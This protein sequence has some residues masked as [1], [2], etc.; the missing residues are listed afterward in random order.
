MFKACNILRHLIKLVLLLPYQLLLCAHITDW[1]HIPLRALSFLALIFLWMYDT[2]TLTFDVCVSCQRL[3]RFW[4]ITDISDAYFLNHLWRLLFDSAL[5]TL[6]VLTILPIIAIKMS[7]IPYKYWFLEFILKGCRW[8]SAFGSLLIDS[9]IFCSV[10][11]C[12]FS[13]VAGGIQIPIYY[14]LLHWDCPFL[15]RLI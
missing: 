13:A 14:K 7:N 10:S 3:Y 6:I 9:S 2:R 1:G 5:L 8:L 4:N 12:L 11:V 15:C